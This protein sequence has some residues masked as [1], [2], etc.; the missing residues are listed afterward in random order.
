MAVPIVTG[1]S[2]KNTGL[3]LTLGI[4]LLLGLTACQIRPISN[5]S[6]YEDQSQFVRLEEDSAVTGGSHSHPAHVTTDEMV[7]VLSGVLIEEATRLT[8]SLP[9]LGKDG[10]PPQHPAFSEAEISFFAPLLAKG[11]ESAKPEEIVTF[12][13]IVKQ[14]GTIDHVTSGGVF[15]DGNQLH[16]L[17]SNYRSPTLYPPDVETMR[18]VDGRS[19]PLQ[20]IAPQETKLNF[21]P[22]SAVVPLRQGVLK[23]PFR[24]MRREIAV[25]F[26]TLTKG[27]SDIGHDSN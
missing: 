26:K 23:N 12:Y 6:I 1:H 3:I 8:P 19:T 14:P 2:M 17:L 16:V 25:L 13:R 20:P 9:F 7:A 22:A 4:A 5:L 10:E 21:Q 15:L 24:P 18:Y 27:A 11:L